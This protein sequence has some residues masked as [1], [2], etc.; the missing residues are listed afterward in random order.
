MVSPTPARAYAVPLLI[1][2]TLIFPLSANMP[3]TSKVHQFLVEPPQPTV[4]GLLTRPKPSSTVEKG[5]TSRMELGCFM[6][7]LRDSPSVI[8]QGPPA[9]AT[10]GGCSLEDVWIKAMF[11][12]PAEMRDLRRE[13][14]M[15]V[16]PD[17]GK[18]LVPRYVPEAFSNCRVQQP[19][20]VLQEVDPSVLTDDGSHLMTHRERRARHDTL[21][22][23]KLGLQVLREAYVAK[24]KLMLSCQKNFPHGAL[25]IKESPFSQEGAL[26][27]VY[28]T[29][30]DVLSH[31]QSIANRSGKGRGLPQRSQMQD[32]LRHE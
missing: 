22:N 5:M 12:K 18:I 13:D 10:Q 4:E 19:H 24:G 9:T 30:R 31:Q 25:N 32:V 8:G 6:S 11:S 15:S 16:N 14:I 2:V 1:G 20:V 27:D 29:N 3:T 17:S 26:K 23:C 28:A 21:T 7:T